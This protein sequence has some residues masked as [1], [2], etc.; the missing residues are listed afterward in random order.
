[1]QEK[2][3]PA[4]IFRAYDIRGIFNEDL[5]PATTLKIGHALG[6]YAKERGE[7]SV[8]VGNDIRTTSPLLS[9]ALISG[10]LSSGMDVTNAGT[11]SFGVCAFS[12]WLLKK[13]IIAYVTAS[14][15]PPEWNGVK[16]Y[17]GEGIGFSAE[18]NEK[19]RDIVLEGKEEKVSWSEVGNYHEVDLRDKYIE[20]IAE[21]FELESGNGEKKIMLDCGNGSMGLIAL[22]VMKRVKL[23]TDALFPNPD[24]SFP[25]RPSE[26]TEE[27]LGALKEEV[28]RSSADFGAAFDGDGD[29]VAIVDDRGRMLSADQC[30][31]I[32]AKELLEERKGLVLAN[33]ECSM[34]IE[35]ELEELGGKIERIPVGHTFLTKEANKRNAVLGIESSGHYVIPSF[36]P[37]DD[38]MIIPLKIAE[39]LVKTGKKLS[40]LVDELPKFPK[41]RMNLECD[42][43]VKFEA[44]LVLAEQLA[45]EYGDDRINTMD[46]IRIDLEEEK[47]EGLGWVLIRA[48]NTSPLIRVTVEGATEKIKD[49]L[50][51]KFVA[52]TE[53]E[54]RKF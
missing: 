42:D 5:Y 37:F 29:R 46:G 34:L 50:M 35:R 18:E 6:T 12:G 3:I 47:E 53:D 44:M 26:P 38:A 4:H 7:K 41:E 23:K 51:K 40:E 20:Y 31:V 45:I 32:I 52:V 43:K 36:F 2:E 25:N 15:L 11:T 49:K 9:N 30:G 22:D 21:R 8:V 14:H 17:T 10:L 28:K 16:L 19:I 27:S 13:D 54:I 33:V 39:I 1:M 48:S 24:P